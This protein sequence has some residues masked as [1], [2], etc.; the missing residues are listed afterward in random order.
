MVEPCPGLP[1]EPGSKLS[2]AKSC[3]HGGLLIRDGFWPVFPTGI[4]F[5]TLPRGLSK[6]RSYIYQGLR[7]LYLGSFYSVVSLGIKSLWILPF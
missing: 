3:V 2:D 7:A 5:I 4:Q 6:H 1:G